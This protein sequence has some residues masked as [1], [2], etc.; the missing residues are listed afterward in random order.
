LMSGDFLRFGELLHEAWEV[1][2]RHSSLISDRYIN[3]IYDLAMKNGAIG[4]KISGAGAGGFMF[5]Y[6]EPNKEYKVISALQSA[7]L[8]PL[9]F[10][11]DFDGLQTWEPTI[12]RFPNGLP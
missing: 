8:T 1:K 3:D 4:G 6:C 7:G 11:F 12:G 2:K 9:S 5:F 10:T